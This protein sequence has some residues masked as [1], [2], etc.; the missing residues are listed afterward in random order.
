MTKEDISSRTDNT[1]AKKDD[2]DDLKDY[3]ENQI[4][5]ENNVEREEKSKKRSLFNDLRRFKKHNVSILTYGGD[6]IQGK[7]I[8]YDEVSNCILE[9]AQNNKI[10]VFGKLISMVCDG[11]LNIF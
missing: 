1:T 2:S 10:V 11:E 6:M 5:S 7:L 8:G 9:T 3:Q 4:E